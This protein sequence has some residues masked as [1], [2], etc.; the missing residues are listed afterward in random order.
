MEKYESRLAELSQCCLGTNSDVSG[1][2][3]AMSA[4]LQSHTE[5]A[6][7]VEEQRDERK[8]KQMRFDM[9]RV[10]AAVKVQSATHERDVTPRTLLF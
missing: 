8:R 4:M 5:E 2:R 9:D 1:L 10:V 3:A 7:R 6:A